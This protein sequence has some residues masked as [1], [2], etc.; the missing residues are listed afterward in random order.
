MVP[1]G[2]ALVPAPL[3]LPAP[4]I[5]ISGAMPPSRDCIPALALPVPYGFSAVP[6]P[7]S[8]G[9]GLPVP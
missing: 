7:V 1:V 5:V 2:L 4:G 9:P 6:V 3:A 8:V